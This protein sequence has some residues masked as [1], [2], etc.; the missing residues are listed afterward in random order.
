MALSLLPLRTLGIA[1]IAAEALYSW[2][3]KLPEDAFDGP[4]DIFDLIKASV[5]DM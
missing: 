2:V 5:R 1:A 3:L 4:D